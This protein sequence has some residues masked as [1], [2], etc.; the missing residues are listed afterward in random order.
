MKHSYLALLSVCV[1]LLSSAG[2]A[3]K[4]WDWV[5][6][7]C[8]P[9]NQQV[10]SK[11]V[12]QVQAP[13]Q[14]AQATVTSQAAVPASVP[15]VYT[16]GDYKSNTLTSKAWQSLAQKDLTGVKTYT[17]K[18][19]DLY[20]TEAAK[21]Q[22]T[23]KDYPAGDPAKVFS[24][25][26]LNDVATSLFIQGEAY[27]KAKDMDKAKAAYQRVVDEFSYG[28]TY[29][30]GSKTFWKPAE[31]ARDG[32]YMIEKNLDLDFGNMTSYELVSKMWA[33]LAKEN[34]DEV[35]GYFR[36]MDSLYSERAKEMQTFLKDFPELPAENIHKYWALNDVGTGAFV[37]GE[38]YS[39][40]GMKTE[41]AKAYQQVIDNYGFSQ[42]WDPQGWFWR[43]AEGA[44]QKLLE[45]QY[46]Q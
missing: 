11:P 23:L 2:C 35:I 39:L 16:F 31:A 44:Q 22:A 7:S 18:C 13:V 3:C 9:K 45:L 20:A 27:R 21:M 43:P 1:L 29:D 37:L 8:P 40:A 10:V 5:C 19:V 46:G 28:Q 41:A 30:P 33:S 17:G 36:K 12:E 25:W 15:G 4:R 26:A 24:Y 14:K 34:L 32:L 42:C 6:T 38:A